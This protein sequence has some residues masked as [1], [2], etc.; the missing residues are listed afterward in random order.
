MWSLNLKV[1]ITVFVSILILVVLLISATDSPFERRGDLLTA[2]FNFVNDLKVGA[3]V[4]LSGVQI[5]RV[6]AIRLLEDA[7]KVQVDLRVEKAFQ[8]LRQGARIQ[9]GIIG[10]VG[11]A[12]VDIKNGPKAKRLIKFSDLPL[13]G[14]DPVSVADVVQGG[15]DMVAQTMELIQLSKTLINDNQ[16]QVAATVTDLGQ[17]IRKIS[18][19]VDQSQKKLDQTLSGLKQATNEVQN[20]VQITLENLNTATDQISAVLLQVAQ[21]TTAITESVDDLI[22]Q[23]EPAITSTLNTFQSIAMDLKSINQQVEVSLEKIQDEILGLTVISRDAI[24]AKLPKIDKTFDEI[25]EASRKFGQLSNDLKNLVGQVDGGTGSFAQL[26]HQPDLIEGVKKNLDQLGRTLEGTT[27]LTQEWQ[28]RSNSLQLPSIRWHSEI[29]YLTLDDQLQN[30]FL[31]GWSPNKKQV[32]Q[33]GF[34]SY[35]QGKTARLSFQYS[36]S[37]LPFLRGRIGFSQAGP[38]VA[39]DL[40][41]FD[42]RFGFT[43]L[44]HGVMWNHSLEDSAKDIALRAELYWK[45]RLTKSTALHWLIGVDRLANRTGWKKPQLALGLRLAGGNW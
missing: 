32:L 42:R 35:R 40:M 28:R 26:I 13:I 7:S 22:H 9:I 4:M 8:R 3:G 10:F 30:E 29:R 45:M 16:H 36:Y 14:V 25:T 33:F 11:E 24:E 39:T 31:L 18:Q 43:L 17:L 27:A 37:I 5:G 21:N 15:I 23:N 2:H 20:D 34:A 44:T 41:L 12:F 1:G 38:R 19:T 6:T